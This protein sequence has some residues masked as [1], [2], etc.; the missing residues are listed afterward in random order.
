MIYFILWFVTLVSIYS[1]MKGVFEFRVYMTFDEKNTDL[2]DRFAFYIGFGI[3]N[4]S[5]LYYYLIKGI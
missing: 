3:S 2:L 1:L 4:L 5:L